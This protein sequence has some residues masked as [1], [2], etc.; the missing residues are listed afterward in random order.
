MKV[1]KD[2]CPVDMVCRLV[3]DRAAFVLLRRLTEHPSRRFSELMDDVGGISTRTLTIRLKELEGCGMISRK[4]YREAPPRVEY[5]LTA[6][7]KAFRKVLNSMADWS[8]KNL[9]AKSQLRR[10]KA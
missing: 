4:A 5:S 8:K 2:Q 7:G 1:S 6:S 10:A 9:P 3:Q